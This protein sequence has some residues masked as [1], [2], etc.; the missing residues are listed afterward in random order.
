MDSKECFNRNICNSF[1]KVHSCFAAFALFLAP[2]CTQLVFRNSARTF[3]CFGTALWD[4]GD[5]FFCGSIIPVHVDCRCL[6]HFRK[7]FEQLFK[8]WLLFSQ[9][10]SLRAR[11]S[12][13]CRNLSQSATTMP[14][15]FFFPP[16]CPK[17]IT[18]KS[19]VKHRFI[20]I[21][22]WFCIDDLNNSHKLFS[23]FFNILDSL[24]GA[25][26]NSN[27]TNELNSNENCISMENCVLYKQFQFHLNHF[28]SFSTVSS[29]VNYRSRF[30]LIIKDWLSVTDC[31]TEH[32]FQHL[33]LRRL[34]MSLL[35]SFKLYP[36]N[37][38]L[39]KAF[40]AGFTNTVICSASSCFKLVFHMNVAFSAVLI[41][42]MNIWCHYKGEI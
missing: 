42:G 4:W 10:K 11:S 37:V 39:L 34:S 3:D 29:E 1:E 8:L 22:F 25:N 33:F 30:L 28:K 9:E 32:N 12:C 14:A 16:K 13:F 35:W 40:A 38:R 17:K 19:C 27:R 21:R 15:S 23:A 31:N 2:F 6:F 20:E 41:F 7:R 26:V 24:I 18:C 5:H 36:W